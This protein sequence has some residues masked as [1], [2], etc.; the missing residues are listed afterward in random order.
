VQRG[1]KIFTK[2]DI[3]IANVH[4]HFNLTK[5]EH[6]EEHKW[7]THFNIRIYALLDSFLF[8][9]MCMKFNLNFQVKKQP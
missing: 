4:L 6:L 3:V 7:L 2:W 5:E 1:R 9:V 8:Q